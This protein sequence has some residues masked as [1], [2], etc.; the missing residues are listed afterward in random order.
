MFHKLSIFWNYNSV[1]IQIYI[2]LIALIAIAYHKTYIEMTLF[3]A[4]SQFNSILF[5][6]ITRILKNSIKLQHCNNSS[7][8]LRRQCWRPRYFLSLSWYQVQVMPPIFLLVIFPTICLPC[9][10]MWYWEESI[11]KEI[12]YPYV[13]TV[14]S[15]VPL[16]LIAPYPI[17]RCIIDIPFCTLIL[18]FTINL[19]TP[20]T[21]INPWEPTAAVSQ[22]QKLNPLN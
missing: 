2:L 10:L 1:A 20:Y 17:G 13:L 8:S 21:F 3:K 15:A 18:D 11:S 7:V 12:E 5:R 22:V 6:R 16:R 19:C 4:K 14:L 9:K